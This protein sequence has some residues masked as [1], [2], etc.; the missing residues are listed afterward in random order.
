M[1]HLAWQLAP[2]GVVSSEAYGLPPLAKECAAF[3]LLAARAIEGLPNTIPS[4]TG[5]RRAVSAGK[6]VLGRA[7]SSKL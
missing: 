5:A 1:G 7:I 6:I 3:A 2:A 4:A